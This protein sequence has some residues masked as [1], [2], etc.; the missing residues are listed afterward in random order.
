MEESSLDILTKWD[1]VTARQLGRKK[2]KSI[3]FDM[4]AQAKI[5]TAISELARNIYLYAEQGKIHITK[6][7]KG[8]SVGICIIASD[9]GPGIPNVE[10]V[11][12]EGYSTSQGL[13]AGLP[14]VKRLMDEF[15]IET[16][17]NKGTTVT[18]KKWLNSS[19]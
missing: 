14:G 10:L 7:T 3:G 17:L 15:D 13:G 11:L 9:S 19:G 4:I 18:I 8:S 6:I 2:A 16:E 1:I 12:Q 5:I